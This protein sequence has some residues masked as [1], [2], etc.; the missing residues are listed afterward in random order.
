MPCRNRNNIIFVVAL[1]AI[2][3]S[4]ST[5]ALASLITTSTSLRSTGTPTISPRDMSAGS[6]CT[7]EGQWYC[8]GTSWQRCAAGQ[9]S[10]VMQCAEGTQCTPNGLS[11]TFAVEY[12][13][14]GGTET[15]GSSSATSSRMGTSRICLRIIPCAF[16]ASFMGGYWWILMFAGMVINLIL[17]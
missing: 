6:S 8:M 3:L 11:Y 1:T 16:V 12:T 5:M 7:E 14:N 15:S 2:M 17:A 4:T 13:N 10:V 9:W